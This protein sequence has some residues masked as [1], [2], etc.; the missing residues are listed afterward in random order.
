VTETILQSSFNSG[1][2]SP[3]LYARVDLAKY[4]SGAALLLNYF[5][6]YRGGASTR[7]GTRYIIQ[8][9]NSAAAV[10]LISFQASFAVGYV[11]EFGDQYIR[12]IFQGAPVLEAA[13][14]ITSAA[15]GPPEVFTDTG[16]GY[17]NGDWIFVG[18]NYYI[19]QNVT[20]NT[21]TLTDLNAN[22]ITTNPFTLP[23]SAARIFT[24]PS[25][26]HAA[27]LQLLKF[28]QNVGQMVICHPNYQPYVLTLISATNWT[29]LPVVIG[30]T[31]VAPTGPTSSIATF[32]QPGSAI[33]ATYYSYVITSIDGNGQE[34][35]PSAP[36]SFGPLYDLRAVAGT[37]EF[38]WST[39]SGAVGYNVYKSDVSLVG[40]IPA[41]I[42]Y[43]FVGSTAAPSTTFID[44]NI[45]PDYTQTP[46]ISKNPFAGSGIASG[47]VSVA[48]TYTAVPSVSLSGGSP[49]IAG[50]VAAVL[51]VQG[52]PT[53]GSGGAGYAVNDRVTFSNGVVLVV[54]TISGSAV[55]TWKPANTAGGSVGTVTVGS[56]P[57]NPVAQLTT[58][59]SGIGATANLTWGVG[60]LSVLA[61]GSGYS[62]APT[63]V[64][65][66][67]GAT[68]TVSLGAASTGFPSV[69]GYFQ[70]RL[71]LAAPGA[72]PSTFYCSQP[73]QY[74]N[75]NV[76]Q[77]TQATDSI[78]GT[79]VSGQLNTIKQM[80]P[81]TSGLL[82][83]TDR[84]SWLINGGS[85]GSA[86][87]PQALVANP[88]SFNGIADI[89]PI[90]AN[91]D[92][93]YVQ[94]KGSIVRDS[95]YNIYANVYTGTDISAI[96][97][98]LFFGFTITGWAWAEEPFKVVWAVRSDGTMLTLTFLKEQE[99]IGWAHST[100]QGSFL[101][102]TAIIEPTATAGNVDAIYTVV[103]R[104]INGNIVK[105]IERFAERT[106]PSGAA[107]A[108]CVDCGLQYSGAPANT[109]SGA[110]QLAGATVT[111][112]ADGVVISPFVMPT[113]GVF[114]LPDYPAN[115]STVTVGLGYNCDLQTLPLDVG[116]PTI[117]GKVKKI[118]AVDIR[119]TD[120]LGLSIGSSFNHLV[121]MKDLVVGNVSSMLT[122]QDNQVVTGLVSGDARTILDPTFTVPGQY[123]IRQSQPLPATIL[124]VMPQFDLG[125]PG[126][127]SR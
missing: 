79:L 49:T 61:P 123:C 94:A 33:Q 51:Q 68:A 103:Q 40:V 24:L 36:F 14:N 42:T 46:P 55:A 58:T 43:G 13:T 110:S 45:A 91:Y 77:I 31:A 66:P 83:F 74:F 112:L 34:S 92:V 70:Q 53:I 54:A 62:S 88:Q 60:V 100:T 21:F 26:Y 80:V 109:F 125:E 41:G 5:V 114:T 98:H 96:S 102:V 47:S 117:Q 89:T 69:S 108:W 50:S 37:L 18:N 120:T 65:S 111:G 15:A 75:F 35:S 124:G 7:A 82:M 3:K 76:S 71:I 25:P 38:A 17:A 22:A 27:D 86:I 10:R 29:L 4:R 90:I 121:P 78:S 99:F 23:A 28:A 64:F 101:S 81:Q 52:T 56:V 115:H 8:C 73:G 93:L 106:F 72:A 16:H 2:W 85:P 44:S 104:T 113:N 122:G 9:R 12:F 105:Y 116:E 97:S 11:L 6:D 32:P 39:V 84:T 30:S 127:K 63:P 126:T 20:T 59:G 57:S 95:V 107:S 119:V 118:Y 19:V 87:S 48:G 67:A 1:E